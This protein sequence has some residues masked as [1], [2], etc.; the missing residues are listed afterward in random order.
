MK[1]HAGVNST[2]TISSDVHENIGKPIVPNSS[3]AAGSS[4]IGAGIH[5]NNGGSVVP[6]SNGVNGVVASGPD[7]RDNARGIAAPNGGGAGGGARYGTGV[8]RSSAQQR[9]KVR[10]TGRG[11]VLA[12]SGSADG[13]THIGHRIR[14]E[15]EGPAV[16]SCTGANEGTNKAL[17]YS[18]DD[19]DNDDVS[20]MACDSGG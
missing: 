12:N 2:A 6:S 17:G 13:G 20:G 4:H 1:T 7:L 8:A 9:K 3:S 5:G 18:S 14:G 11:H 19:E 15:G 16:P 10:K